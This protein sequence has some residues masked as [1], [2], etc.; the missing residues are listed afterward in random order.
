MISSASNKNFRN[1]ISLGNFTYESE[2]EE[3]LHDFF[4]D[5]IKEEDIENI[6]ENNENSSDHVFVI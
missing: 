4:N 5:N 2:T 6:E 3:Q 1:E